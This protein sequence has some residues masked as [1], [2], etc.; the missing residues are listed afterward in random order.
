MRTSTSR[1]RLIWSVAIGGVLFLALGT[2]VSVAT[3]AARADA[4]AKA[5]AA[6]ARAGDAEAAATA[7]ARELRNAVSAGSDLVETT[8]PVLQR[9]DLV[10]ESTLV[11]QLTAAVAGARDATEV[12]VPVEGG[13]TP[14]YVEGLS[15]DEYRR[16]EKAARSA[17]EQSNQLASAEDEASAFVRTATSELEATI[18]AVADAAPTAAV[19]I[20][21][22][23]TRADD[24]MRQSV[25]A[26]AATAAAN[27]TPATLTSFLNAVDAVST[28]QGFA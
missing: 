10:F 24:R 1:R 27:P 28:A 6:V 4:A 13:A 14:Q 21:A 22:S 5:S 19:M 2:S 9:L 7:A 18:A 25:T 15:I 23:T 26:A 8:E 20:L 16:L 12:A 3:N 17:E 11:N